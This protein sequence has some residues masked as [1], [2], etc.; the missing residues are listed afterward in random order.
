[1]GRRLFGIPPSERKSIR[2]LEVGCGSGANLW[3]IAKEGFDAFGQDLSA[4]A[5]VL[6]ADMMAYY[7]VRAQ[8]QV[9]DM[10]QTAYPDKHFDVIVDVFSSYCLNE[11]SYRRFA[12]EM[13]RLLRPRGVL[14]T[15][16]PSKTSDA[17]KEHHPSTLIDSS[18][19]NG[20]HRENSPFFGNYYPF[21]FSSIEEID[22]ALRS[23]GFQIQY[24]ELV[25]R[26]Y[27]NGREYFEFV[28]VEAVL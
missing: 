28:V 16:A 20:V 25:G 8:L 5:L 2:V 22:L 9:S 27:R 15:Y 3:M 26:T 18:T 13:R 6:C 14:F 4:E 7:G 23:E 19:L 24:S 12:A 11:N 1:M 10:T 17:F 21:R